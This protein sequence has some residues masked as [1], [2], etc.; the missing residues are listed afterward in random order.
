MNPVKHCQVCFSNSPQ[1][2]VAK[3][4]EDLTSI[5]QHPFIKKW[6]LVANTTTGHW[7]RKQI[8]DATANHIF[9]GPTIF[10][11]SDSIVKHLFVDI[12]GTHPQMPDYMTLPVLINEI[13]EN[14]DSTFLLPQKTAGY[15]S[16]FTY[17]A[18]KKLATAFKIFYT[19]SQIPTDD[20]VCYQ[21]LFQYLT[22][23]FSSQEEIFSKILH[24]LPSKQPPYSLHIF[25][26]A[27]LPQ[28]ITEFFTKISAFFPVYFYCFSPSQ[29]YF[30]DLLSDKAIDFVWRHLH[31]S[32]S[33]QAWKHYIFTDRQTLL[34]NLSHKSQVSQNFFLDREIDS[35]EIFVSPT[36]NSSLAVI[37]NAFLNLRPTPLQEVSEAKQT[38]TIDHAHNIAREVQETFLKVTTLLNQGI[39]PEEIFILSSHIDNYTVHL[40]ATFQPYV[41]LYFTEEATLSSEDLRG[42]IVLLSSILQTQGD[43][44]CLF[45]LL[46]HPQ[47]QSPVE[48]N[49]THYLVKK[50]AKEWIK[51]P[52]QEIALKQHIKSL[53]D[54]ILKEYP[55][56]EEEGRVSQVEIWETTL[57][58][59]YEIQELLNVYH[60]TTSTY[61]KHFE[62][63]FSFLEKTFKLS[64]D[65]LLLIASLKNT[66]LPTYATSK[67]SLLFFTDFCLDFLRHFYN[68]SPIYNKPGPYVGRLAD[69]SFIP[70]G[71]TFILGANHSQESLDVLDI[72]DR[73]TTHEELAF[74][75]SEDEE[76]FHFLQILV[77]TKY[78]L[79]ISYLSSILHPQ[80]PSAFVNYIQEDANL[81]VHSLPMKAYAP[82]SFAKKT[83]MHASQ[84]YYYRLA[85]SF[86]SQK[87]H[88]PSLFQSI[89][90]FPILP[91]HLSLLQLVKSILSP[92]DLF[93]KLNYNLYFSSP[94]ILGKRPKFFPTKYHL[95]DFWNHCF[96]DTPQDFSIHFA[97]P[98]SEE[99]FCNYKENMHLWFHSI[100]K[101]SKQI[102]YSV[103]LSSSLFQDMP[104]KQSVLLP[105]VELTSSQTT[106]KIH[107]TIHG[108]CDEGLYFCA[109]DPSALI[110]KTTKKT[111]RLPDTAFEL[112]ALLERY[113]AMAILQF[114]GQLPSKAQLF[115]LVSF[116]AY[117]N[118]ALPFSNPEKYLLR[119]LEVYQMMCSQPIPLISP[120][121]WQYLHDGEKF[122]QIVCKTIKEE[123]ENPFRSIFWKF[124]NRNFQ[125]M[126][127]EFD[128]SQRLKILSL[129]K[130][131]L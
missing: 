65:E 123:V 107:G 110:K 16:K 72:L 98:F 14:P 96:L 33:K 24:I 117:E 22:T 70:K 59:I 108:V 37:Q 74:S 61:E 45:Q 103:V 66:L 115:K 83:R 71:Y 15:A 79:H 55:F 120:V 109:I 29:E 95:T 7:A 97:S 92:L 60:T 91:C 30:G 57:P 119:V 13:L 40:K 64:S 128:E 43:Q 81:P 5:Y 20:A 89:S 99:Q 19:F 2:L 84:A 76:N 35:T 126:F 131:P 124:H 49:K 62:V 21:K 106:I 42:K 1:K 58:L 3:L 50:L 122:Q 116:E 18:A 41:P 17:D 38:I 36:A 28:H 87:F 130:G 25:G 82:V 8:V 113:I 125:D 127:N 100:S 6:I 54:R 10:T 77:S 56:I 51:I 90:S 31:D 93:L 73:A 118:I 12:C 121:C 85:K 68:S 67:C 111:N 78:A 129:F 104:S 52:I 9:M 86:C 80:L 114:T 27:N 44:Y 53:G 4:T 32:P 75:S 94:Q 11:S 69:L 26:Y 39:A 46:T 112:E 101:K 102:P 63:I 88:F 23:L 34:A 48:P 47:L 105:P